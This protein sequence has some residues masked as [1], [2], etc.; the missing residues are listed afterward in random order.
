MQILQLKIENTHEGWAT[1]GSGLIPSFIG[2][3]SGPN[4]TID[5][6]GT[7]LVFT[8]KP[9]KVIVPNVAFEMSLKTIDKYGNQDINSVV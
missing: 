2:D 7:E 3:L 1:S 5:V 4:F 8:N 6:Q 9:P